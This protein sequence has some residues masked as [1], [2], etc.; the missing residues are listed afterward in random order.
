[1]LEKEAVILRPDD[2]FTWASGWKS[3]I[4]C[5]NRLLLSYPD[6]RTFIKLKMG[7]VIKSHFR[8]ARTLVGVATAGIAHAALVGDQINLPMAYA[9]SKPKDHG[10]Q[11]ILEGKI[12]DGSNVVIIEDL[13]STGKS[14]FFVV[15][16][17][18]EQAVNVIGMVA[19]FTYGFPIADETAEKAGVPFYTL[20]DYNILLE[21]ALEMGYIEKEQV[22]ILK[23]WRKNPSEWGK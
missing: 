17:L 15:N 19:I 4:Y 9:R 23:E 22:E 8:S 12:K 2:P 20:T 3:P 1:M 13:I 14:S 7:E 6:V 18:K 16:T 11:N 10:R 5:D 21:E